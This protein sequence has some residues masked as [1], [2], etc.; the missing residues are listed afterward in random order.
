M[1]DYYEI[2]GISSSATSGQVKVAYRRLA[3]K[4]HP[5]KN[6]DTPSDKKFIEI[7]NAYR[8]LSNLEKRRRYDQGLNVEIDDN[9][10]EDYQLRRRPPPYYYKYKP[11]KRIYSTKDYRYATVTVIGIIIVAI[12]FPVYLLQVTSAKYYDKAISNYLNGRY[13]SALQNVDLSIKDLSSTNAE[14]SALASVILVHKLHKFDFG[15][16]YVNRGLDY[17]PGDS[18]ESE[19]HYLKGICLVKK[20]N[21]QMALEEFNQVKNY[22]HTYDSSLFRSALILAYDTQNL[23]SA[24]FLLNR[25]TDRNENHYKASYFKGL[26]YERKSDPGRAYHIFSNLIGKPFNQAASYFHLAKSEIKLNLSDSA[27]AHLKIAGSLNL[28]ES[29]QLFNLY[30]KQE[31]IFMSPYD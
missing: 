29:K 15:L 24:E 18:L 6:P 8:I 20:N 5:D 13:Y 7:S 1:P 3:L 4:Y 23:D 21:P 17:N 2:L 28:M 11:E 30:C 19:L 22:S 27:C 9:L 31:S 10:A 12:I 14:A 16:K 26:I 25:L